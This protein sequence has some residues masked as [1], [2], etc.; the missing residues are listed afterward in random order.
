M[1]RFS[2]GAVGPIPD[3]GGPAG[4]R[5][6]AVGSESA[7]CA[8]AEHR[9]VGGVEPSTVHAVQLPLRRATPNDCAAIHSAGCG[10]SSQQLASPRRGVPVTGRGKVASKIEPSHADPDARPPSTPDAIRPAPA[11]PP[12]V[13]DSDRSGHATRPRSLRQIDDHDVFR[14]ILD[15]CPSAD[16]SMRGSV[17]RI[18]LDM[19]VCR[20][21]KVLGRQR[22]NRTHSPAIY[23][24]PC[25]RCALPL[26][27][28]SMG[29]VDA[30]REL[31]AHT[32]QS[33]RRDRTRHSGRRTSRS[34]PPHAMRYSRG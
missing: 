4:T 1:P 11:A 25:G 18:G 32:P 19:T 7:G 33:H 14:D 6:F 15:G 9:V 29:A 28:K 26:D 3:D 20:R 23:T 30:A 24:R 34:A 8:G 10:L 31:R 21:R 22:R 2:S 16:G 17:P 5:P 13:R 12:A 27:K